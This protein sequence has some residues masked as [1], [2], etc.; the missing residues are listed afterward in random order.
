MLSRRGNTSPPLRSYRVLIAQQGT[1]TPYRIPL[2]EQL[3]LRKPPEWDFE[4]VCEATTGESGEFYSGG[5]GIR[6]YN[7]P[8]LPT[9]TW[10]FSL[11]GRRASWQDFF[12]QARKYDLVITDNYVKILTYPALFLY[13]LT[14]QKRVI[15][16][17]PGDPQVPNPKGIKRLVEW[18]KWRLVHWADGFFVYTEGSRDHLISA[19]YPAERITVLNNTIDINTERA[20]ALPLLSQRQDLREKWGIG[21]DRI[22]VTGIGRLNRDKRPQL[23]GPLAAALH[24]MDSRFL[25]LV[26]GD[27]PFRSAVEKDAAQLGPEVLRYLG[28]L[29]GPNQAQEIQALS[30][31]YYMP[32]YV[33]LAPLQAACYNLPIIAYDLD[34]HSP[35][36]EYLTPENSLFVEDVPDPDGVARQILEGLPRLLD[37]EFRRGV[38]PSI[39]HLT[40][41]AMVGRYVD[42]INRVL[43][44]P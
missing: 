3:A 7:F 16:G 40:M 10:K 27:G 41:D 25:F 38:W 37:P 36:V 34:I 18:I 26:A 31:L 4:V 13:K 35:E 19:G 8:T 9:R 33:G 39:Q 29:D 21:S 23:I 2:F 43:G 42:G 1:I 11:F 28:R 20:G 15:W 32:G 14:G 6:Q 44:L 24:R 12:F 30:D 17:I 22:V 5:A